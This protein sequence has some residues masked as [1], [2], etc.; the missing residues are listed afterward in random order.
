MQ[1]HGT[2]D[3][4]AK[5]FHFILRSYILTQHNWKVL[6]DLVF[7]REQHYVDVQGFPNSGKG[8]VRKSPPSGGLE[9]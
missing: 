3:L 6:H 8:W 4:R 7:T 9:S 1:N 2:F 5:L